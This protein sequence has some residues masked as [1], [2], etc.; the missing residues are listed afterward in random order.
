MGVT[1]S[2]PPPSPTHPGQGFFEH[3]S[4]SGDFL[5]AINY[6]DCRDD[7]GKKRSA[8]YPFFC[9]TNTHTHTKVQSQAYE[10]AAFHKVIHQTE[11]V[12]EEMK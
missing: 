4:A 3:E 1:L 7:V 6:F 5:T 10:T 11:P 2:Q 12:K 9:N 8:C